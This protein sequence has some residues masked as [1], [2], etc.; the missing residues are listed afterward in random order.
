[1][2]IFDSM[3]DVKALEAIR[4]IQVRPERKFYL[5]KRFSKLLKGVDT[6]PLNCE[7]IAAKIEEKL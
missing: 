1:M 7:E 3:S 5:V 6:K 2:T 4:R